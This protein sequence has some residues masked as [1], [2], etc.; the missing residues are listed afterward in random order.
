VL[1]AELA[2][3]PDVRGKLTY[4]PNTSLYRTAG[5]VRYAEARL[6]GS[7]RSYH[8]ISVE[9]TPYLEATLARAAAGAVPADLASPLVGD[10][11]T[12][13]EAARTSTS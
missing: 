3:L 11:I 2:R 6:V 5:R 13:E 9:P 1:I 8:L 7:E 10:D 12:L 4:R